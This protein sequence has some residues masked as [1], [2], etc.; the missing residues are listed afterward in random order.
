MSQFSLGIT[1]NLPECLNVGIPTTILFIG[2]EFLHAH[3]KHPE[4][5]RQAANARHN[6]ASV[7]V[8]VLL[9]DISLGTNLDLPL[10][11]APIVFHLFF[12]SEFEVLV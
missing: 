12:P 11:N 8:A 6:V 2:C 1:A 7:K 4:M 5:E 10:E 9:K 3:Q